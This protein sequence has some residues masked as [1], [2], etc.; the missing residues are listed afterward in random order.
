VVRSK[1]PSEMKD[2]ADFV[3]VLRWTPGKDTARTRE[4]NPI[5]L[6]PYPG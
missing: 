3:E 2:R 5:K 1:K 6:G 4:E